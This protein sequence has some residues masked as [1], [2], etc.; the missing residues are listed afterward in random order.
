[1]SLIAGRSTRRDQGF[2]FVEVLLVL[3]LAGTVVAI[4]VGFFGQ[5]STNV[6]GD[7]NLRTLYWQLKLARETAINERRAVELQLVPPQ[8]IRLVRREWPSGTTLLF[9]AVLENNTRFLLFDGQPDTP[10]GFGRPGPIA[11]GTPGAVMFTAD[12]MFTDAAGNPVN[13]SI[14]LGQPGKTMTSRA[15]TIFGPTATLRTYRWNGSEWRR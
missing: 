15:L 8:T 3:A 5:A 7:A 6:Q 4:G 11:F 2:T 14:F 10:D 13:G 9:T 1:M 12:G